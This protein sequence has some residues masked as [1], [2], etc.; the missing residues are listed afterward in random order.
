MEDS[1]KEGGA[2]SPG[3]HAGG[4]RIDG[5]GEGFDIY[6][7]DYTFLPKEPSILSVGHSEKPI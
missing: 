3:Y 6:A 4:R 2:N 5:I 1:D 7:L